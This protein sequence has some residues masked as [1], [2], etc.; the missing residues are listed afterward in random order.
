MTS[1]VESLSDCVRLFGEAWAARDIA[2]LASLLA[3]GY[4]HTDF[5][6]RVLRRAEWLAYA[7]V[8]P[9]G[10][11]VEFDDVEVTEYGDLGVVTGANRIDGGSMGS[12]TIRFTQV[13]QR[14]GIGWK[15]L[16]FQ[17]TEVRDS[18]QAGR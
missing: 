6:G 15:R 5:E 9:H 17:A 18:R 1:S 13:W 8:Q 3:P 10:S 14:D 16:A 2:T 12:S 7:A 11:S 4:V